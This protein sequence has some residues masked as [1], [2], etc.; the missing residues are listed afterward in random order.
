VYKAHGNAPDL[1][2]GDGRVSAGVKQQRRGFHV[3]EPRDVVQRRVSV[4]VLRKVGA[5]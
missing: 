1:S 5:S 3:T 2:V 4:V